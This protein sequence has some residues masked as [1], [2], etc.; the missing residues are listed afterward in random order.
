MRWNRAL[1]SL[2]LFFFSFAL[3]GKTEEEAEKKKE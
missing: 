2:S 3:L 1:I